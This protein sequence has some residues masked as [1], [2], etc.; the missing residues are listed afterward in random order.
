[1]KRTNRTLGRSVATT[2]PGWLDQGA[3]RTRVPVVLVFWDD[4]G[5]ASGWFTNPPESGALSCVSA[6]F[7][8][9]NNQVGLTLASAVS[10]QIGN[11]DYLLRCCIPAGTVKEMRLLG[12][13]TLASATM[14]YT[15]DLEVDPM[16]AKPEPQAPRPH[17]PA[18]KRSRAKKSLRRGGKRG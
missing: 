4:A 12:Y 16:L 3:N 10:D 14:K 2:L 6:G 1:M 9:Y 11:D 15:I 18:R 8:V 13:H 5:T 17:R 7:L